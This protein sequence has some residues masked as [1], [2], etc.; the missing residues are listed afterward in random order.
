MGADQHDH[1]LQYDLATMLDRRRAL[2]LIVAGAGFVVVSACSKDSKS[3]IGRSTSTSASSTS[4]SPAPSSST[5]L[6]P[7]ASSTS[8]SLNA[9]NCVPIPEETA[10]PYPGDGSNGPNALSQNGVVRRDIRSSF[11]GASGTAAGVP[12]TVNLAILD[13][14]AGCKALAGAA[15]Y[16]WHC[17]RDG[18]YSMYSQAAANQNYLRG[19]QVTDGSGRVSFTTIFPGAY[20]GRWPHIH[21][22]VYPSESRAMSASG[23][24]ATSQL[25]L[26]KA[27]CEAV[28]ATSG[29]EPS[30]R[31]LSQTS[32]QTDNVFGDDGGVRQLPTM[33][34]SASAGFTAELSVP[35]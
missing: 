21:F 24:L 20:S 2:K 29:Y 14:T 28:Y 17:D 27:T 26:P 10:G 7:G 19:V 23:L 30:S 4:S 6:G 33:G 9:A 15:V 5:S 12:L 1:G 25:A 11:G 18:N 31:N 32:L 13:K 34:G 35:V 16:I 3:A 8:T 22:E